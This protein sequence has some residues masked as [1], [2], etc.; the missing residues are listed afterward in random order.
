MTSTHTPA[1]ILAML[2][3]GTLAENT[4]RVGQWIDGEMVW[5]ETP[6]PGF[7]RLPC[8]GVMSAKAIRRAARKAQA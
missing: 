7:Y 2:E 1:E 4:S 5:T 6:D 8:G 3:A